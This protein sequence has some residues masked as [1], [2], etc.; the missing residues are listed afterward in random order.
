MKIGTYSVQTEQVVLIDAYGMEI[1][2]W[3]LLSSVCKQG[4]TQF[5]ANVSQ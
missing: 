4:W 5:C 2:L 3:I 1:S